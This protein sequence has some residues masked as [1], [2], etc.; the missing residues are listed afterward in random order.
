VLQTNG[1][2]VVAGTTD[3]LRYGWEFALVP[4][5]SMR[6]FAETLNAERLCEA[7]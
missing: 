2:I 1:R 3:D 7:S 5:G 6:D 4:P